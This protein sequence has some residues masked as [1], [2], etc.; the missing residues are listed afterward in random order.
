MSSQ[1]S[2]RKVIFLTLV[3]MILLAATAMN[4]PND[5]QTCEVAISIADITAFP[6]TADNPITISIDNPLDTIIGF[7]LWIQLD[8]PPDIVIFRTD[9]LPE[10]DT[11]YWKCNTYSGPDCTD[12]VIV[13]SDSAWDF[14]YIDTFEVVRA[15]FDTAG[16][17]IA[18][19]EYVNVNSL[20]GNGTDLLITGIADLPGGSVTPGIAPQSGGTLVNI[21]ADALDVSDTVVN[22]T[23]NLIVITTFVDNLN[24]VITDPS[25]SLFEPVLLWDT[26]YWVC[27]DWLIDTTQ[28]P[29]DTLDCLSWELTSGPPWDSILI[30]ADT[31]YYVLDTTKLCINHGSLEV[32]QSYVCGDANGD[33]TPGNILDLTFLVDRIFRGGPPSDPLEASD[34]N[35]DGGYGNI[36]DLTLV[37]DRIFR[38]GD[39]VCTA[40]ACSK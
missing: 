36:L 39:P 9:S 35:C 5:I 33:G 25:W 31:L 2:F 6:N 8:R 37:V 26:T 28:D 22:R 21:L 34:L 27:T 11:T 29:P 10:Y 15:D 24:I 7:Q 18:G 38:G 1:I 23:A 3:A 14:I 16:T 40:V 13:P 17:L 32:L 30:V 4:S 12:S 20:A 19:W